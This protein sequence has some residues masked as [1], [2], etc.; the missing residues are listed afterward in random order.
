MLSKISRQYFFVLLILAS[1]LGMLKIWSQ[2]V[3]AQ[4]DA[5]GQYITILSGKL[6]GETRVIETPVE[7]TVFRL[8]FT[9]RAGSHVNMELIS[10]SGRPIALTSRIF[11]SLMK[12]ANGRF[13]SG[14][15]VLVCGKRG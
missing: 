10:P 13:R 3:S 8:F 14:T 15:R 9:V 11:R 5:N 6:S 1:A 12:A 7:V 2:P 4:E